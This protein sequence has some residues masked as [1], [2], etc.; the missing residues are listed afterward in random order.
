MT[1]TSRRERNGY[2]VENFALELLPG[3][4]ATGSIYRPAKV[5][6]GER[7]PFILNP[8]GHF[9]KGRY[10]PEIQMRCAMFAR[11]GAI[12][13]DADLFAYGE[14]LL[15]FT[16]QDHNNPVAMIVQTLQNFALID[17]FSVQPEVD[18]SRIAVVGASGGGSQAMMLTALDDRVAVSAPVIMV[19]SYYLGGCGCE[20]G[21]P[22][23]ACA[24]GTNLAEIA[25][26]AAPR[27]QL[28]VSDGKDW[29]QHVDRHEYPFIKRTYGFYGAEDRVYNEHFPTEGHDWSPAKRRAVYTFIAAQLGLDA[30]AGQDA[31]GNWDESTLAIEDE[32]VLKAFGPSGERFPE[33]AVRGIENL[34]K[35]INNEQ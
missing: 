6:P 25:A 5:Q 35:L 7:L 27:P 24:G 20:S 33:T 15:A 26:M 30:S 11:M 34:K 21:I 29:T 10:T 4:Y 1:T 23:G 3:L 9:A 18:P 2:T 8:N 16:A 31:S 19:S 17:Y 14:S 12:A 22:V 32:S 28:I 13:V